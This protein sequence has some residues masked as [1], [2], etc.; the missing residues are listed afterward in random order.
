MLKKDKLLV[1]L[2]NAKPKPTVCDQHK[3]QQ[4][5]HHVDLRVEDFMFS[6]VNTSC[7]EHSLQ[8]GSASLK[9]EV[10]CSGKMQLLHTAASFD[11]VTYWVV[12]SF[13]LC[14]AMPVTTDWLGKSLVRLRTE[15]WE[16]SG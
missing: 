4:R 12:Q 11:S 9:S 16:N 10:S 8:T 14:R 15:K 2:I 13:M 6:F 3:Q 1:L 7:E 5:V